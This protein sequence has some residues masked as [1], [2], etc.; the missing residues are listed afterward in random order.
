ME[1]LTA[2]NVILIM[3]A[4]K[5]TNVDAAIGFVTTLMV[6]PGT[7]PS[8]TSHLGALEVLIQQIRPLKLPPGVVLLK[9]LHQD[10]LYLNH[11]R[12]PTSP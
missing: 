6:L 12:T 5:Y 9:L 8:T 3:T 7:K 1:F 10:I 4:S 2:I 11:V